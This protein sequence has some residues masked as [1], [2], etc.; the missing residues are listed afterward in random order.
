MQGALQLPDLP[1]AVRL[2]Q[3]LL[4]GHSFPSAYVK[5]ISP[6][7]ADSAALTFEFP[8]RLRDAFVFRPGQ[9]LTLRAT[10]AGEEMRRS[11]SICSP[12]QRYLPGELDIGIKPVTAAAS[13]PG[14]WRN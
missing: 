7:A 13:R 5:R 12:H 6:D 14:P 10:I 11:Y 1:R 9:F 2:L 8:T 3:A 4:N